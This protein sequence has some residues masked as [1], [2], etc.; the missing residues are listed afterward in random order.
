MEK[1]EALYREFAPYYD[2]IYSEKKYQ[3]EVT[4]I[5][6]IIKKHNRGKSILDVAC[7]T[8]NH[9][10][11]LV[12]KGYSVVGVDKSAQVLK[13]AKKKVPLAEFKQGDMRSFSLNKKFDAVL[14][15]FTA[16]NYNLTTADLVKSLKNFKRHLKEG[17]VIIFDSPLPG[18]QSYL[19]AN[20]VPKDLVTLYVNRDIKKIREV[21]VYWIFKKNKNAQ[22]F[23]DIHQIRFYSLSEL[24][25]AMKKAGL[26]HKVYWG[27]SLIQKKRKRLVLVCTNRSREQ[28]T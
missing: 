5:D 18:P 11:L 20:F 17:G 6:T 15:M 12:K 14:C 22:V 26:K 16:I 23:K 9:A 24:S 7:G 8:G 21:S 3:R 10:R 2:K 4:F 13:L 27:F 25:Q 1:K 28:M 19:S